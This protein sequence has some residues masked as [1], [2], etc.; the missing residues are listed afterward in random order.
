MTT[1]RGLQTLN[2]KECRRIDAMAHEIQKLGVV[3]EYD[4]ENMSIGTLEKEK[5]RNIIEIET[6]D[7]HRIAMSFGILNSYIWG[8]NVLDKKCVNKTYPN[9]WKDLEELSQK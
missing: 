9:F 1:L 3:V 6:Y 8:L 5:I 4:N 2:L 7:D